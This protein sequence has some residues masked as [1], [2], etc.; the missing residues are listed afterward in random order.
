MKSARCTAANMQGL[1][2]LGSG[3]RMKDDRLRPQARLC[4]KRWRKEC[5][6]ET[7]EARSIGTARD[8]DL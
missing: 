1:W 6:G 2:C 3:L 8:R 4:S 7:C 5:A